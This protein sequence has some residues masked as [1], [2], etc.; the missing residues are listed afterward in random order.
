MDGEG[1]GKE[2]RGRIDDRR[3]ERV[4]AFA[5]AVAFLLRSLRHAVEAVWS[6]RV[7]FVFFFFSLSLLRRPTD[8]LCEAKG[9]ED[10]GGGWVG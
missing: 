8:V 7:V 10:V 5:F 1:A 6:L 9:E 3:A 4:I 2:G